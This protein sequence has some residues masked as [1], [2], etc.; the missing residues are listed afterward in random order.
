MLS[1]ILWFEKQLQWLNIMHAGWSAKKMERQT[2]LIFYEVID[3]GKA[4]QLMME[5]YDLIQQ[6][7]QIGGLFDWMIVERLNLYFWKQYEQGRLSSYIA[8]PGAYYRRS[9]TGYFSCMC[10]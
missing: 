5:Y 7:I 4:M 2:V 1:T 6:L 3:G 9:F 10:S 8:D